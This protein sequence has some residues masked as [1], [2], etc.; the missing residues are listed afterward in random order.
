[1]VRPSK[2]PFVSPILLFNESNGTWHMYVDYRSLNQHTINDKF[3]NPMEVE[4][5]D[6]LN[7]S[8]YFSK[9]DLWFRHHQIKLVPED[10]YKTTF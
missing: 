6:E 3:P 7:G 4:L 2:S 1:M 10:V 5:L 9:L 8:K